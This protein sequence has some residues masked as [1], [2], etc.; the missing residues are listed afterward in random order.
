MYLV[1]VEIKHSS[2]NGKGVFATKNIAKDTIVWKYTDGHDSKMDVSTFDNLSPKEQKALER[3][4][5]LS[6]Q[7]DMWVSPPENDPACFTNHSTNANMS[8][9]V[10]PKRSEEPMF[11][12][13]RAITAG[14][15]LTNNYTDFDQNSDIDS[16]DWLKS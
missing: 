1:P 7:S 10:D 9:V 12:A 11:I 13:D 2:I 14:E 16:F 8:V 4:S 5:Y 15:E 3:I 6:P